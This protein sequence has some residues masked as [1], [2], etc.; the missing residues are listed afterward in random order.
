MAHGTF[1]LFSAPQF[2]IYTKNN[3]GKDEKIFTSVQFEGAKKG[4]GHFIMTP[5][6]PVPISGNFR[7]EFFHRNK[8]TKVSIRFLTSAYFC[9]VLS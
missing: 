7:V 1:C 2:V 5:R 3:K 4:E 8:V 6:Q 9:Q